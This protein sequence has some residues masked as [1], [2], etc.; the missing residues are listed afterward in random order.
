V[1]L[2]LPHLSV[3]VASGNKL[4]G[5]IPIA[6][7]LSATTASGG[8][9]NVPTLSHLDLSSNMLTG[10]IP[11]SLAALPFMND[12]DLS[13]NDLTG[14][15]LSPLSASLLVVIKLFTLLLF[16][17]LFMILLNCVRIE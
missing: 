8:T 11:D 17:C 12:L 15:H 10:S 4:S 1:L 3:L 6:A 5:S 2:S 13:S 16:F 14:T 7:S 9:F